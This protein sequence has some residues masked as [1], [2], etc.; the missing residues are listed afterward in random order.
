MC[1]H[2]LGMPGTGPLSMALC[3]KTKP[4]KSNTYKTQSRARKPDLQDL[5]N[6]GA[7]ETEQRFQC[8]LD[9]QSPDSSPSP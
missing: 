1:L 4:P 8:P 9:M 3:R 5:A 6:S 7:G 2:T